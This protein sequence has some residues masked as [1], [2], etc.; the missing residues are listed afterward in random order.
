MPSFSTPKEGTHPRAASKIDPHQISLVCQPSSASG[1]HRLPTP[2]ELGTEIIICAHKKKPFQVIN[3]VP[4]KLQNEDHLD[5]RERAHMLGPGA[6][7]SSQGA[8]RDH[9]RSPC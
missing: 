9:R 1:K 3:I 5:W 4:S 8:R 2:Q 6:R 7:R